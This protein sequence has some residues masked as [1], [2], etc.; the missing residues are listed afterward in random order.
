[1]YGNVITGASIEKTF[2]LE[3][4]YSEI[5]NSMDNQNSL[6]LKYKNY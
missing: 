6:A 4:T 5:D 1:M 2:R 3:L